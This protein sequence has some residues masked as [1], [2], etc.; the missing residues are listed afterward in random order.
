MFPWLI[1]GGARFWA[2]AIC[3]NQ[4][5]KDE[6]NSQIPL[7]HWVYRYA[8]LV[9]GSLGH[10][11]EQLELGLKTLEEIC[12]AF[13]RLKPYLSQTPSSPALPFV[14][15]NVHEAGFNWLRILPWLFACEGGSLSAASVRCWKALRNLAYR[16]YFH[17]V[18]ISQEMALALNFILVTDKR[19]FSLRRHA[20][21]IFNL[22]F[23]PCNESLTFV[24][25]NY[26]PS[27]AWIQFRRMHKV[28][29]LLE[30]RNMHFNK[31]N[32][33]IQR[34]GLQKLSTDKRDYVYGMLGLS[35]L[36]IQV[37]YNK[38]V[39]EVFTDMVEACFQASGFARLDEIL[40]YAGVGLVTYDPDIPSFGPCPID[41]DRQGYI[42]HGGIFGASAGVFKAGGRLAPKPR[43]HKINSVPHGLALSLR[44]CQVEKVALQ[45]PIP[46]YRSNELEDEDLENRDLEEKDL[47]EEN[48]EDEDLEDKECL[49]FLEHMLRRELVTEIQ[50]PSQSEVMIRT[51]FPRLETTSDDVP[52]TASTISATV[53]WLLDRML[54]HPERP[55][56]KGRQECR[57]D[58]HKELLDRLVNDLGKTA[59]LS[60][61]PRSG[62]TEDIIT[63]G[64]S[65][66]A[67]LRSQCLFET[68]AGKLGRGPAGT[69]PD[70]VVC[71][72]EGVRLPALLRR[73]KDGHYVLVGLCHIPGLMNGIVVKELIASRLMEEE[74]FVLK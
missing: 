61:H 59:R 18:W 64:F 49:Q 37:D 38:S 48:L 71:V 73:V 1:A 70:D 29:V 66:L 24:R 60:S 55:E 10:G 63:F 69:R 17:R 6:K 67:G 21:A 39:G 5:D 44:G 33:F 3:I 45:R 40:M 13:E 56:Y 62:F 47:K 58:R 65:N 74:E 11:D 23:G 52:R 54:R 2:D 43:I 7:L 25:P 42:R 22:R 51:L 68:Y 41:E 14:S 34:A 32:W 28:L 19:S 8:K 26:L 15:K 46:D 72:L 57:S 20:W 30:G 9:I 35:R 36:P 50:G 27:Q 4:K 31:R 12:I 53:A 16:P